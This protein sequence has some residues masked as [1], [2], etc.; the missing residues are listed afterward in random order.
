MSASTSARAL[1]LV[2]HVLLIS[3]YFPVAARRLANTSYPYIPAFAAIHAQSS[4]EHGLTH[5]HTLSF[6]VILRVMSRTSDGRKEA[7]DTAI[8]LLENIVVGFRLSKLSAE[9]QDLV[10][11]ARQLVVGNG[12]AKVREE[13]LFEWNQG[14]LVVSTWQRDQRKL[15]DSAK[16]AGDESD[17]K[18][19]ELIQLAAWKYSV[20]C[21]RTGTELRCTQ[22]KFGEGRKQNGRHNDCKY[23]SEKMEIAYRTRVGRTTS[24]FFPINTDPPINF[25]IVPPFSRPVQGKRPEV[26]AE[27]LDPSSWNAASGQSSHQ[28]RQITPNARAFFLRS[29]ATLSTPSSHLV[30][31]RD[32]SGP[33]PTFYFQ[34]LLY[35]LWTTDPFQEPTCRLPAP[36]T[37]CR[38]QCTPYGRGSVPPGL[39]A[40]AP[41]LILPSAR[42]HSLLPTTRASYEDR[43]VNPHPFQL[44]NP[45][46][47]GAFTVCRRT[48]RRSL[49]LVAV[50]DKV[51]RGPDIL[52]EGTGPPPIVRATV[53]EIGWK[54]RRKEEERTKKRG[55]CANQRHER[56]RLRQ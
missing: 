50:A 5:S 39:R 54:R 2:A 19:K 22:E 47:S 36:S 45:T 3:L 23:S 11:V 14:V 49:M 27:Y 38:F 8:V 41:R 21:I 13:E 6:T 46:G 17:A 40:S 9:S 28:H 34:I 52:D 26:A 15:Y 16:R 29:H 20:E 44:F 51:P 53:V 18:E 1:S 42:W 37:S 48:T 43:L 25:T 12:I 24:K 55:S 4:T 7:T 30:F 32:G 33:S 56:H 31:V 35:N 10:F